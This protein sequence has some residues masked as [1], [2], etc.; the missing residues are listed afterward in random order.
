MSR[1]DLVD[2]PLNIV[3]ASLPVPV[4]MKNCCSLPSLCLVAIFNVVAELHPPP[5]ADDIVVAFGSSPRSFEIAESIFMFGNCALFL[6]VLIMGTLIKVCC[7]GYLGGDPAIMTS[8]V[9]IRPTRTLSA[10]TS[11]NIR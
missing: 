3:S 9:P 4:F 7:S 6:I 8:L 2:I 11:S 5:P 1:V 10:S